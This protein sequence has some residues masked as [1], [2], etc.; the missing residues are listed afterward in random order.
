MPSPSLL[1]TILHQKRL[2]QEMTTSRAEAGKLQDK[3]VTYCF[4]PKSKQ[5]MIRPCRKK[6]RRQLKGTLIDQI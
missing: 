5:G 2:G 4:V 1:N 6:C 3:P